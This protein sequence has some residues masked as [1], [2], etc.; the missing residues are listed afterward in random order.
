MIGYYRE[1]IIYT[2]IT[3]L[4]G[5]FFYILTDKILTYPYMRNN[6]IEAIEFLLFFRFLI[7]LM[8]GVVFL[9][10]TFAKKNIQYCQYIKTQSFSTII[11][12]GIVEWG[13]ISFV[14]IMLLEAANESSLKMAFIVIIHAC[15]LKYLF[16]YIPIKIVYHNIY[17]CLTKNIEQENPKERIE[18][19][20]E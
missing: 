8:F 15:L 4:G 11:L 9:L 2:I 6:I 17:N 1:K 7:F 19:K 10:Y 5:Y 3:M 16:Y 20:Q 12:F 13:F 18:K 14:V